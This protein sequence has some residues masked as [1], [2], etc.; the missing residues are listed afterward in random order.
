MYC[1]V[2]AQNGDNTPDT[3]TLENFFRRSE[4]PIL[5]GNRASCRKMNVGE[6]KSAEHE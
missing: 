5:G 2:S 1:N 4:S 6:H 3:L